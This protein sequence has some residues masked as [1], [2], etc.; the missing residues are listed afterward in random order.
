MRIVFLGTPPW[1]AAYLQPLM[2]AGHA[3]ELVLTQPDKPGK[4]G[5]TPQPPATKI[6]AQ[7]LGLP[8]SQPERANA[9][10]A[11]RRV[12]EARP[13]VLL[14]VAYGQILRDALLGCPIVDALNVHYSLLPLLRGPAP[15]QHALLQGMTV[16]GVSLQRMAL[17]VDA[18]DIYAFDSLQIGRDENADS[19]CRRLTQAGI[20]LVV[21]SLP[22]IASGELTPTGQDHAGA[23][24]APLLEKQDQAL[25]FSRSAHDVHN[26]VRAF[27]PQPGAYCLFRGKRLG[28]TASA[29]V[30]DCRADAGMPGAVVEIDSDRGPV[31]ATGEGL[32]ELLR[33]HPEGRREMDA[34]SWLRGA[35]V[36]PGDVLQSAVDKR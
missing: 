24:Y 9:P 20:E 35:A 17:E 27:A 19:L 3:V 14:T 28:V 13:D 23:S 16:T 25:D 33:V 10:E 21:R 2:D 26:R 29:V 22:A 36:Q 6:E 7:R 4:R 18:G 30:D 8:V 12:A 15:V 11:V 5:R 34:A 1:A 32:I 31:V